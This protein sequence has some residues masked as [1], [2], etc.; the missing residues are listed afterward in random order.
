MLLVDGIPFLCHNRIDIICMENVEIEMI[1]LTPRQGTFL[2][3]LGELCRA[4]GQAVHY[5]SV[6]MRLGVSRFSAYDMLK[7][8]EEKGYARYVYIVV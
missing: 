4:E 3:A 7:V 8:L 6:A 1:T 5:S 2:R